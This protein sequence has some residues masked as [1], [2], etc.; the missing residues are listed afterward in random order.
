MGSESQYD[1]DYSTRGTVADLGATFA[2]VLLAVSS[3][4]NVLQGLSAI[5]NDDLYA[6]GSEYLYELDMTVWGSI[7]LVLGIVGIAVGIGIVVRA[8][9]AQVAGMIVAGLAILTN[10]AFLPHYPLWSIVI[11][12]FNGFVIWALTVQL[13]G[14]DY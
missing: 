9:W 4:M 13:R 14:Y 7:H 11:I 10:F 12:A 3:G 8:S 1:I 6:A 5:V 2:A